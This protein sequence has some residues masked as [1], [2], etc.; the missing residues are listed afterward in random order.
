MRMYVMTNLGDELDL[1]SA[2]PNI[3][4]AFEQFVDPAR[5]VY[6]LVGVLAS[7]G[8]GNHRQPILEQ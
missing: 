3:I 6:A 8:V 7:A 4:F 2:R 1:I 5:L